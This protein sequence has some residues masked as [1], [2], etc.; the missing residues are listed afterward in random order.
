M[1]RNPLTET[2]RRTVR[3]SEGT[4]NRRDWMLGSQ[5]RLVRW[6]ECDTDLPNPGSRPVT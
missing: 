1:V 5:R 3:L 2:C 4:Q 6:W